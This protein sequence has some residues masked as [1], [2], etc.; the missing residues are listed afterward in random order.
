MEA[1]EGG[2]CFHQTQLLGLCLR[3]K[4]THSNN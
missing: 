2:L 3:E 4:E 1:E